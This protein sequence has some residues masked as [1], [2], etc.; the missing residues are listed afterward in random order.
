MITS[1]YR[2]PIILATSSPVFDCCCCT[3]YRKQDGE[4]ALVKKPL[5]ANVTFCPECRHT[6]C[7]KHWMGDRCYA[8]QAESK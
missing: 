3:S 6:V 5:F 7:G 2:G 8:C 4:M 1:E